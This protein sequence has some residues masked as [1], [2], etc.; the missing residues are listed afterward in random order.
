MK[1]NAITQE[2]W[3][4]RWRKLS[5]VIRTAGKTNGSSQTGGERQPLALI[6]SQVEQR[7]H[8]GALPQRLCYAFSSMK[9]ASLSPKPGGVLAQIHLAPQTEVLHEGFASDVSAAQAHTQGVGVAPHWEWIN[10]R[11][12]GRRPAAGGQPKAR[13]RG[14]RQQNAGALGGLR[15]PARTAA[16]RT[17]RYLRCR[18]RPGRH[19]PRHAG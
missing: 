6:V 10:E 11:W 9:S 18:A 15:L 19:C 1:R 8:G 14:L 12:R 5:G 3:N 13:C 16:R 7:S 4:K 17:Q 2:E